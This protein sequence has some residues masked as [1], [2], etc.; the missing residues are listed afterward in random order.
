MARLQSP[1]T[2]L[3]VFGVGIDAHAFSQMTLTE[4]S[5]GDGAWVGNASHGPNDKEAIATLL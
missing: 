2:H 3:L 1:H 5:D 4:R